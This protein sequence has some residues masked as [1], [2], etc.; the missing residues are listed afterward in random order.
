M[1]ED[2]D[3]YEPD[4]QLEQTVDDAIEYE[5]AAHAPVITVKPVVAQY[6]PA[7]QA[8]HDDALVEAWYDPARQLEHTVEEATEYFPFV[9]TPLTADRPVVA[10]YEPAGHAVHVEELVEA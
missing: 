5:P 4:K 10:Q 3:E 7:G 2:T 8:T 9:Q 1:E 6:D